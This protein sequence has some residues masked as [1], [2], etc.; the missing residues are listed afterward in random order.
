M[1]AAGATFFAA[2]WAASIIWTA[3]DAARRC[4]DRSLRVTSTVAAL[5]VPFVGAAVYAL[6]RPCE[7]RLDV[8]ARRLRMQMFE[9]ALARPRERCSGCA[10]PL[11][12][13]FRCCPVCGDR[14]HTECRG[15]GALLRST[16]AVC[17]WCAASPA[18]AATRRELV[19]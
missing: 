1:E 12:P 3:R 9:N 14:A 2:V 4:S 10:A 19:A 13:E 15:C 5:V 7:E 18:T 17:P 11:E 6:L 16:W 8:K